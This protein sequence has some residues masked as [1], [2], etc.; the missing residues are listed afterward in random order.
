V[1]ADQD[2]QLTGGVGCGLLGALQRLLL[3]IDG[4]PQAFF[5][6]GVQQRPFALEVIERRAALHAH[7]RRDVARAGGV[8]ALAPKQLG[9][10]AQQL[11]PA[12][13]IVPI[14]HGLAGAPTRALHAID[15]TGGG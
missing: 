8:E 15:R 1:V 10:R 4:R 12:V 3:P 6:H 14:L 11:A 9:G 2:S 13:A 5:H 7:R